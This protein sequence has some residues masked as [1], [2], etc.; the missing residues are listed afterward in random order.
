MA[1]VFDFTIATLQVK[2]VI[3]FVVAALSITIVRSEWGSK[4]DYVVRLSLKVVSI[5]KNS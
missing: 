4:F 1:L 3:G 2:S 5:L